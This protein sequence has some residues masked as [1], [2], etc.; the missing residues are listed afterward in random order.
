MVDFR[1]MES[2]FLRGGRRLR[3]RGI[4]IFQFSFRI[5][6]FPGFS[7]LTNPIVVLKLGTVFSNRLCLVDNRYLK[8]MG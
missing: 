1:T 7:E 6:P 8:K 5:V 4:R 2:T 3:S